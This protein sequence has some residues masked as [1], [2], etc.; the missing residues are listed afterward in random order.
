[1][2][3]LLYPPP[4]SPLPPGE[5][6]T[7]ELQIPSPGWGRVRVGVLITFN[8]LCSTNVQDL[9]ILLRKSNLKNIL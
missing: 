3:F 6:I 4:P 5:G 2:G 9:E 8:F 7:E 1:M